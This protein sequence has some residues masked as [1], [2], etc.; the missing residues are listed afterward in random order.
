MSTFEEATDAMIAMHVPT[1]KDGGKTEK[2]WR[3]ILAKYAFPRLGG[4][5]V[6]VVTT[7]DVL[8]VLVPD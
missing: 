2:R 8:A 5:P 7:A 1:W 4:K 3:A 6:S